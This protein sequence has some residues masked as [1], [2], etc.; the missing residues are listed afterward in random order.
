MPCAEGTRSKARDDR[1]G[2]LRLGVV[3]RRIQP[4]HGPGGLERAV[5]DQVVHLAREGVAVE[6]WTEAP[7]APTRAAR[8]AA[9]FPPGVGMNFVPDRWLPLGDRRGTIVLDRITNY[10]IWSLR[11]ARHVGD[12]VD[13]VHAHGLGAWGLARARRAGRLDA[14]LLLNP[15]GMEEFQSPSRL[16][17]WAYAPFRAMVRSAAGASAAVIATDDVL[18]EPV[19]R[20]LGVE[21][22]RIRVI[23]NAV[24]PDACV[25]AAS[26]D[27]TGAWLRR[28][29][30]D[31]AA[32]LLL[33]IGRISSNKGFDVLAAALSRASSALPSTWRW[34]LVGDGPARA[35]LERRVAAAGIAD[36]CVVAGRL[37]EGL[38]HG[39]LARADWFVHPTLYEGSSLVTLEAMA[40]AVPIIATRAGGI[41]D[42]VLDGE[43]GFLV[44]PGSVESLAA[45]LARIGTVDSRSFGAR[46]RDLCESRF[47]WSAVLPRYLDLYDEVRGR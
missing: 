15:Q 40:H 7:A 11:V 18:V 42:K 36:R 8:A 38:K 1:P 6:V 5:H 33:S 27:D 41:P 46:G 25:E 30:L 34:V 20:L 24:D 3:S 39:L 44:E 4:V 14:P 29:Q 10:P 32:P 35:D 47:S 26:G 28:Q 22:E 17:H 45:A 23:P 31:S 16:K 37:D 2:R 13:V 9:A 19:E 43:S 12:G 21:P